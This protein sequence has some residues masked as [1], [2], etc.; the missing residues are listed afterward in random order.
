MAYRDMPDMV[1][2]APHLRC[3]AMTKP[4]S[5]TYQDWR[6]KSHRC[7]RKAVQSRAGHCVCGVHGSMRK[8]K[9]WNGEPDEFRHKPFWKWC[10]GLAEISRA[11]I[12]KM[13]R[14]S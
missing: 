9:Y 2:P 1:V 3:E 14:T 5:D 8:A 13:E 6:R 10:G 12:A 4:V 11:V 7:V